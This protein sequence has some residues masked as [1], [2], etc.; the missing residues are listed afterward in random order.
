MVHGAA[1][2]DVTVRLSTRLL[3]LLRAQALICLSVVCFS[4][5]IILVSFLLRHPLVFAAGVILNQ[6]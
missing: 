6:P 2:L 3:F 4:D 1:E 5:L